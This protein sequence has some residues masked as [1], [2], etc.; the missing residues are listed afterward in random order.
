MRAAAIAAFTERLSERLPATLG[1]LATADDAL[2]QAVRDTRAQR[3]LTRRGPRR[4]HGRTAGMRVAQVH[5]AAVGGLATLLPQLGNALSDQRRVAETIT[6]V[7]A[8]AATAAAAHRSHVGHRL[9]GVALADGEG[10]SFASGWPSVV[11]ARRG[12]RTAL[13]AGPLP[14]V[15]HLRMA[16]PGSLAAAAVA[17]ELDIPTVFTLA[18]DPHGPIAAA[19]ATGSLDRQAFAGEDARSALWFRARLVE[20]LARDAREL[21]LFPRTDL[22]DQI[23]T[24]TGI[25]L[26]AGPPRYTVVPEGIDTNVADDAAAIVGEAATIPAV[27]SDLQ[28]AIRAL[29]V[30][31][32]GLPLVVSVGRLHEHKGMTRLVEA[33]AFDRALADR[34]NLVI[35]GGDV[36]QPSAS[37]SAE[38]ARIHHLMERHPS[39]TDKVVLLGRRAHHDVALVLASAK[40]G[41][42]ELIAEGGAYACA[43]RKEEFGLAVVEAMAAGL[44][45]VA[46]RDGGPATYVEHG[47]TGLL[48]D[49]TDVIA[50][51]E[52]IESTLDLARDASTAPRARRVV[53]DRFTLERMARTM[54]AVYRI[55]GGAATLGLPVATQ[56]ETA[57]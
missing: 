28:R 39:L 22:P 35:V 40:A 10:V 26:S 30:E 23:E 52:A 33:F 20:R 48:V 56:T 14:D 46:P 21:V 8:G 32:H 13:L 16:D 45:V 43:S 38:L 49:T 44:P 5:L 31:R 37:E 54:S 11:A 47:L 12:I 18:P 6:I 25:D 19:E 51:S 7:R 34:A 27:I 17:R 42:G 55:S 4:D 36:H 41:W 15:L 57:A 29:P 2:G 53:E 1:P 24:L 3:H 50:L 9:E